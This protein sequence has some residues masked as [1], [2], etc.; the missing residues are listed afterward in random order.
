MSEKNTQFDSYITVP[1]QVRTLR[2]VETKT[3]SKGGW[4]ISELLSHI[5]TIA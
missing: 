5:G 4:T 3:I 1:E 2:Q